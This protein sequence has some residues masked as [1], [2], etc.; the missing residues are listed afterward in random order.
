MRSRY[1]ALPFL[2]LLLTLP[3]SPAG[4]QEGVATVELTI[5][6]QAPVAT[7]RRSMTVQVTARH[8]DGPVLRDLTLSLWVYNPARSRSAYHQGLTDEPPTA[9]LLISPTRLRGALRPGEAR[10]LTLEH[11]L[12]ALRQRRENALYPIKVQ[13]ESEGIAVGEVRSAVVFIQRKP[14]VP[15]NVCTVFVLDPEIRFTPDGA[16]I[17]TSLE[18][19]IAPGGRV[20]EIVAALEEDLIRSTLVISPLLL[21]WLA[22]MG[23]GYRVLTEE[24]I[25][26]V[27][28]GNQAATRAAE[29]L[30]RI[31]QISRSTSVEV[32]ALPYA[33]PSL[34]SLVAS[35]LDED[36]S[37]QIEEG[38]HVVGEILGVT[39]PEGIFRPPGAELTRQAVGALVDEGI[40]TVILDAGSVRPPVPRGSI[41]SPHPTARLRPTMVAVVPDADAAAYLGEGSGNPDLDA[42]RLV[43]EL[44]A[45]YFEQP[46]VL[47]GVALVVGGQHA[48]DQQFIRPLLRTMASPPAEAAWLRPVKATQLVQTVPPEVQSR[49]RA[50]GDPIPYSP[51]LVEQLQAARE[52]IG[53]F[54]SMAREDIELPGR[55]GRLLLVAE[56]RRFLTDE[57]SALAFVDEVRES[58]ESEYRKIGV[59]EGTSVTLTSQGGVIPVTLASEA[60]YAVRVRITLRSPRLEFLE[61]ASRELTLDGGARSLTFPVRANTTGRFPVRVLLDT[62]D[63]RRIGASRLVVRSTAYNRVALFVTIAAAAFLALWAGRRFLRQRTA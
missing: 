33:D 51:S 1:A 24:G 5:T 54:E 13:L 61:G 60:D 34:P 3:R 42:I 26:D 35:G 19:A 11:S 39:I 9:P 47:R 23:E 41:L 32:L 45:L 10:E 17:G 62:P 21:E 49:L 53:E 4:A 43:G 7:P 25:R 50:P 22:R 48:P 2:L 40:N 29:M 44:G 12:R 30:G 27:G 20:D 14:L 38:R 36:L 8:V 18:E 63:G 59:P 46:S 55:L 56:A 6:R 28:A 31:R 58:L 16:L 57:G 37:R 52:S 15:L